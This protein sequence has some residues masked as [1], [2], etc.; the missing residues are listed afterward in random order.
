M[1][2]STSLEEGISACCTPKLPQALGS[3][4]VRSRLQTYLPAATCH[5]QFGLSTEI[6]LFPSKPVTSLLREVGGTVEYFI[7]HLADN[8]TRSMPMG[9]WCPRLLCTSME[10]A[11]APH[12]W[13]A[14]TI[15]HRGLPLFLRLRMRDQGRVKLKG[16]PDFMP[17]HPGSHQVFSNGEFHGLAMTLPAF[18]RSIPG[19][20]RALA[21][22]LRPLVLSV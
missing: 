6:T 20:S 8:T 21:L 9:G 18:L 13:Q 14:P 16:P 10:K 4:S 3:S 15:P 19:C 5:L 22:A 12:V 7:R 2:Y 11:T 1:T 17:G